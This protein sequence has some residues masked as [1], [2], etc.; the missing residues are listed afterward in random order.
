MGLLTACLQPDL[1]GDVTQVLD[2]L[3]I[4]EGN[5]HRYND[6]A[7]APLADDIKVAAILQHV[8]AFVRQHLQAVLAQLP[9]EASVEYFKVR[10]VIEQFVQMHRAQAN[11]DAY[12]GSTAM[13]VDF[14]GKGKGKGKKGKGEGKPALLGKAKGKG[15]D[16]GKNRKPRFEGACHHCGVWGH[17]SEDYWKKQAQVAAVSYT[18]LTLPTIYSV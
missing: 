17:K 1:S 4:W 16:G 5:V 3:N 2:K 15:K 14:L 9:M 13:Q 18:H 6:Q 12:G 11:N 7:S 8:G 10:R